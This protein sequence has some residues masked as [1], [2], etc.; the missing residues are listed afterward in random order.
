MTTASTGP[1]ASLLLSRLPSAR[2]EVNGVPPEDRAQARERAAAIVA[3]QLRDALQPGG[4]SVSPMGAAWSTDIDAYLLRAVSPEQLRQAGW[5]PFDGVLERIGSAGRGRWLVMDGDDPL[6]IADL[7]VGPPPDPVTAVLHRVR[8][9]GELRLR[10]V[11]ELLA[12]RDAGHPL[13]AEDRAVRL[14]LEF[15]EGTHVAELP[16]AIGSRAQLRL[17]PRRKIAGSV[18]RSL[19][20]RLGIAI[21]GVDGAGKSTVAQMLLGDL[22]RSGIPCERVWTRPGLRIGALGRV[23]KVVKRVIRDNPAPAVRRMGKGHDPATVRSRRGVVGW[24]WCFL[25]TCSF[26]MDVRRRHLAGRGI[27]LYDRHLLDALATLRFAYGGIDTR[28]HEAVVSRLVPKVVATFYLDLPAEVAQRRK[29]D[30]VF[31]AHAVAHQLETYASALLT[32]PDVHVLDAL[33]TPRTL[34]SEVLRALAQGAEADR[35]TR[36]RRPA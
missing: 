9:R 2:H 28:P 18:R 24:V 1:Q 17:A 26:V 15:A 4:L 25:V 21:S 8:H 31:G 29:P 13:P 19:R 30:D 20:P 34:A 16:V 6:V 12:L 10:E 23:S 33:Q 14:A 32:R 35:R 3:E 22:A 36:A 11:L 7:H 27:L 5:L